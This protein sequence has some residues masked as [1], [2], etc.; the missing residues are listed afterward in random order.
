MGTSWNRQ[1]HAGARSSPTPPAAI[2][3]PSRRSWQ[4]KPNCGRSLKRRWSDGGCTMSGQSL[5][6]DEVHRWNKAQ[7]DALLPHVENGTVTFIGATTENPFFEVIGALISRSRVFQLRGLNQQETGDPA[8][9]GPGGCR[10][11]LSARR[12]I[13]M[14]P[15]ARSAHHRSRQRRRTQCTECARAGGRVDAALGRRRNSHHVG[16]GAGVHPAAGSALRQGRRRP[17]RH[18]QRLHQ[19]RARL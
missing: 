12:R 19:V 2:L 7:Q 16:R 17:L 8:G 4:A 10:S 6:V 14:S 1:D 13:V 5:F 3:R 9:P 11:R 18:H 15:E